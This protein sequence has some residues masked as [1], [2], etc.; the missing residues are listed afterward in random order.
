MEHIST[1]IFLT[2]IYN[3]KTNVPLH[4]QPKLLFQRS[5]ETSFSSNSISFTHFWYCLASLR[6]LKVYRL[7]TVNF[8]PS[9]F[10]NIQPL[11]PSFS[12]FF[13]GFFSPCSHEWV[14]EPLFLS[15]YSDLSPLPHL[16]ITLYRYVEGSGILQSN[17]SSHCNHVSPASIS[18][19]FSG[20]IAF[21]ATS[22]LCSSFKALHNRPQPFFLLIFHFSPTWFVYSN[23]TG[24]HITIWKHLMRCPCAL[25]TLFLHEILSLYFPTWLTFPLSF[26][27]SPFYSVW[28]L[29]ALWRCVSSN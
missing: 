10:P 22:K 1:F 28:N 17:P 6:P 24:L 21:K 14:L 16:L 9:F 23:Q 20:F 19:T 27:G 5:P 11:S 15:L 12:G 3:L 29:T 7:L 18:K 26:L 25:I 4:I 2:P 8:Y 13:V